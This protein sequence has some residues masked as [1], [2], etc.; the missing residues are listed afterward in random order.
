MVSTQR[1]LELDS[2]EGKYPPCSPWCTLPLKLM[3]LV[4]K[5]EVPASLEQVPRALLRLRD[6]NIKEN[7]DLTRK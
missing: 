2:M 3:S 4:G 1:N 6:R 7:G 5:D